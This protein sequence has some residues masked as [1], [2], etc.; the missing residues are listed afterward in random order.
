[1]DSIAQA[2]EYRDIDGFPGYRVGDDGSVWSCRKSGITGKSNLSPE[3]HRL[4]PGMTLGGYHQVSLRQGGR[5]FIRSIH[6][7]VLEAFVGPCPSGME[8]CHFPNRDKSDNRLSNL[9]WGTHRSNLAD[10]AIHGTDNRGERSSSAKLTA[11]TVAEIR[12]RLGNGE[13][14]YRIAED[15]GVGQTTISDINRQKRWSHVP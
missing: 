3:W 1:M 7:L 15:F 14:Q 2:V 13:Y 9:R 8:A 12:Q 6:R 11:A 10:R 5:T 4:R